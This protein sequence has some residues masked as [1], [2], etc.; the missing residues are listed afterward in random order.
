MNGCCNRDCRQGR[1]CPRR[2]ESVG[3]LAGAILYS[4]I[5]AACGVLVLLIAGAMK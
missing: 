2:P 4:A 5:V 1:T 3:A